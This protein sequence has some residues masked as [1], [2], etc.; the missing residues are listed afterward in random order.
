MIA[1][2]L[3]VLGGTVNTDNYTTLGQLTCVRVLVEVTAVLHGR[4]LHAQQSLQFTAAGVSGHMNRAWL[5]T[6]GRK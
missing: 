2:Q 1:Q 6:A 5:H 3:N 4:A